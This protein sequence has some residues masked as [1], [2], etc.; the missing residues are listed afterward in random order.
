MPW[1]KGVP[2]KKAEAFKPVEPQPVLPPIIRPAILPNTEPNVA[3][4]DTCRYHRTEE[5]RIF[6][7]GEIIPEGW[8]DTPDKFKE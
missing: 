3:P 6:K 4:Y 7:T 2:R 5:P 1:P 8:E